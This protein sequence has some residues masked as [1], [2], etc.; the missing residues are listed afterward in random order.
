MTSVEVTI[1]TTALPSIIS[2]LRGL[3]FQSWIMSSYLLTTAITTPIY[4]KLADAWG[5]KPVFEFGLLLFTVGSFLSGFAPNIFFLIIARC[6]QGIG[7]GAVIPLT[8]TI[9]ADLYSF[10]ERARIMAFMNTAW[11]LSALIGPLLGGFLVDNLSWHWVFF[12]NVPLGILVLLVII[13]GYHEEHSIKAITDIDKLGIVFLSLSLLLLLGGIQLLSTHLIN[14]VIIVIIAIICAALFLIFEKKAKDPIIPITMFSNRTFSIQV[15][16]AT[17]LS[18]ILIGYQTYFPI[19]LQS[20]YHVPATA[21][22]LVVTSSSLM[23]LFSSFFVGPLLGKFSPKKIIL[24]IVLIQFL[25]YLP[26]LF[27]KTTSPDWIFYIIAAISGAG[28][29]IIISMNI[30]LCQHLVNAK[31]VGSATAI[32]TLGRSLG[33]TVMTG[34]YGA[35]L[36]ILIQTNLNNVSYSQVNKI[37]SSTNTTFG[38]N[39]FE[40]E[41]IILHA[42][43]G[44]FGIAI[45]LYVIILIA[46][47]FDPNKKTI[48]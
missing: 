35:T 1:V 8:F 44:V 28:M 26:L 37:I 34:V 38:K 41:Q 23:W 32:I 17:L 22:G 11:G 27:L 13:V 14:G 2:Q 15:L 25:S 9:I 7:A 5:R 39:N 12:V 47:L 46:N 29:G 40:I 45:F 31:Q 30:I 42:L 19:W 36:N 4:G 33:P 10:K 3:S 21:S 20:L 24:V 43:H 18:S 16:T 6:I 48:N